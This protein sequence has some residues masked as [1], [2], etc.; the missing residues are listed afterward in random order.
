MK[1]IG[2]RTALWMSLIVVSFGLAVTESSLIL[3]VTSL[4]TVFRMKALSYP[5]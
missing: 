1:R 3:D 5:K 2:L 4:K